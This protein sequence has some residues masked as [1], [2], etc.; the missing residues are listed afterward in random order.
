MGGRGSGSRMVKSN[1][2]RGG[3]SFMSNQQNMEDYAVA[4]GMFDREFLGTAEGKQALRDFM[5]GER[6]AGLTEREM[7][8]AINATG[9]RSGGT[10]K[11]NDVPARIQS[12]TA[13][14]TAGVAGDYESKTYVTKKGDA[15]KETT[16]YSD[17]RRT[18]TTVMKNDPKYPST[19][20]T[21]AQFEEALSGIAKSQIRTGTKVTAVDDKRKRG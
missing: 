12:F 11:V 10:Y 2:S 16:K 14:G 19:N 17:G 13:T 8:D 5:D 18:T 7:R 6:E 1:V 4:T 3:E 20:R 9:S 21:R 15:I